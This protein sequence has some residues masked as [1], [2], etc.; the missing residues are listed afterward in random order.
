MSGARDPRELA[1]VVNPRAASGHAG[2]VWRTLLAADRRLAGSLVISATEPA[3]AAGAIDAALATGSIRRL[4]VVGGDGSLRL[5]ADRLLAS[6]RGHEVELALVPAGTGSDFART[7]RLPRDPR[8]ALTRALDLPARPLDALRIGTAGAIHYA[9]NVASAGISGKVDELVN[10]QASRSALAFLTATLAALRRYRPFAARVEVDGE[11]WY[12]GDVFLLAVA[13]GR[14]FGK[15]MRIAPRAE[16]DDGL[17]DVV[18]VRP[19]PGWQVPLQLPRLYLGRH[20]GSPFV[21]WRRTRR[22][23][24]EPAGEL[25]PFDLDGETVP[26]GSATFEL[27][28]GALRFAG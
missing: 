13:N 28:A 9:L 23:R 25:P 26:S 4:V 18:L 8:V 7:L 10:A 14:S 15:G 12:A 19:L 20:L 22:V 16:V 11:L 21:E 5:A 27:L 6:G 1:Y 3:E 2:E 17:A 24:F